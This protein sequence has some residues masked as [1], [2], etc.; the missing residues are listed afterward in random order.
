MIDSIFE[1]GKVIIALLL[2]LSLAYLSLKVGNKFKLSQHKYIQILE[3]VPV[4]NGSY[5]SVV[6]IGDSFYLM[7]LTNGGNTIL[8]ELD[9]EMVLSMQETGENDNN[10]S[11][12]LNNLFGKRKEN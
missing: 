12:N 2:V 9:K 5:I 11:I 3:R 1:F 7:S 6:K 8:K 10:F 4:T